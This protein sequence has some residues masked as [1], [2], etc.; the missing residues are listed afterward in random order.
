MEAHD[1]EANGKKAFKKATFQFESGINVCMNGWIIVKADC[2]TE[3]ADACDLLLAV[4]RQYIVKITR[5]QKEESGG[6]SQ[7]A[8][9]FGH[10]Y[11]RVE[12][13]VYVVTEKKCAL[14]QLLVKPATNV[15]L[16][17]KTAD[18]LLQGFALASHANFRSATNIA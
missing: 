16:C 1:V 5:N 18:Q 9:D 11:G 15:T 13:K 14:A 3:V 10:L 4:P 8:F 17:L 7:L 12:R 6:R 2:M